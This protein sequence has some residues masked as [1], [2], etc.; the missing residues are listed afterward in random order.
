[1]MNTARFSRIVDDASSIATVGGVESRHAQVQHL[2]HLGRIVIG[3][4]VDDPYDRQRQQGH[5]PPR[6]HAQ[7]R[8]AGEHLVHQAAQIAPLLPGCEGRADREQDQRQRPDHELG[9]LE[10]LGRRLVPG[11]MTCSYGCR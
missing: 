5:E 9:S 4:G 1:M 10:Q 7:D 8:H 3:G 11:D 2:Q 6:R